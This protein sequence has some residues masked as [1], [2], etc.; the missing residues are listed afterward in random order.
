LAG[1]VENT[2]RADACRLTVNLR[3]GNKGVALMTRLKLVDVASC[4]LVAPVRYSD[5]Y[6]SLTPGES[7]QA[8]VEFSTKNVSGDDVSL[9]VDG[10]NASPAELA[11][12]HIEHRSATN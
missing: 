4:L 11:R 3:N 8:T 5:N 2:Q 6:F 7:K 10:W 1:T 9:L 12:V